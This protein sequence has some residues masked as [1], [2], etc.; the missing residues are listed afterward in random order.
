M[1]IEHSNVRPFYSDY[2]PSA[3]KE[4]LTNSST[5]FAS[6]LDLCNR[7]L[8]DAVDI[9]ISKCSTDVGYE[10]YRSDKFKTS[11]RSFRLSEFFTGLVSDSTFTV[12]DQGVFNMVGRAV[13]FAK[14]LNSLRDL[15]FEHYGVQSPI[16]I[17]SGYR[18]LSHN[19]K[20][21]GV[22]NS[23]HLRGF[24]VDIALPRGL[25]FKIF[26][27]ALSKVLYNYKDL[28]FASFEYIPYKKLKFIHVS[29]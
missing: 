20:V 17:N 5:P 6:F 26:D 14:L 4:Y 18:S 28:L 25:S 19:A 1:V 16:V 12:F 10:Y 2:L 15:I 23:N 27:M 13:L 22:P 3:V 7:P 8:S 21:K 9:L 11:L 29:L 24:A